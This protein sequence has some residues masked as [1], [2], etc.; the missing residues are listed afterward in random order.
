MREIAIVTVGRSDFGI[1]TP[2][3]RAI[4][5]H[6]ELHLKLLV[7]GMHLSPEF[8]LTVKEIEAA[9]FEVFEKVESLLSSDT[10]AG[11][12]QSIGLGVLS[13]AQLFSRYRPDIMLLLGDRFDML[14]AGLAAL[15]FKIPIGHIHGGEST[16][17]AMDESIRHCLTKLSHLHFPSTQV[18]ADRIVQMGEEPWRVTVAGAL[19][20][21]AIRAAKLEA[22]AETARLFGFS[23][24]EPSALV[25]FH[26][27]TLAYEHTEAHVANL[28][29]A[30]DKL[31]IQAV[32][33]SPN[34]DM[35]GRLVRERIE[36]FCA[37]R[38][39]CSFVPN[40]GQQDYFSLMNTVSVMI[41]N[42]SS[43]IIEAASFRLP[44]VNIGRRQAGRLRAGN[45]IDSGYEVHEIVASVDKGLSP[46]FHK[47][48]NGLVNPYG[49]GHAAERIIQ[50][51]AM[52]ALGE[53]LISKH[54][55]DHPATTSGG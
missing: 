20:L 3:L 14:P 46:E 50:R 39:R 12:A 48:L 24:D 18:Y 5:S 40:V 34:S 22:P 11:V 32:F 13:F 26:P 35:G 29:G 45:V 15:P 27:E 17:G 31:G 4:R 38:T 54:F 21:D 49:D 10:A 19:A 25:T 28:L 33:T 1:Y 53:E 41:G 43:G 44:V 9:G 8:G 23:L 52:V 36:R 16:E 42:S 7:S 2:L 6:P 51:L 47:S 30:L 55:V 37:S